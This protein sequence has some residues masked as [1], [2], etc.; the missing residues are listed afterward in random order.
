ME[1]FC[2]EIPQTAFLDRQKSLAQNIDDLIFN[3]QGE[4][5]NEFDALYA[6][7]FK[8]PE[9]YVQA[10]TILGKKKAGMTRVLLREQFR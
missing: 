3:P 5:Y 2:S 9:A 6:S 7:L 4:L 1:W 10:I 8:N